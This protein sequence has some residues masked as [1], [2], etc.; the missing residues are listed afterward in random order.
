MSV[1]GAPRDRVDGK[2]K[3]TG[4]AKYSAEF[5]IA[6][7]AYAV[8]IESTIPSGSVASID[9]AQASRGKGVLAILTPANAPK[10]ANPQS[11]LSLLQDN[12]VYY[13]KQPIG[14]VVADSLNAAWH[15]A[16][17]VHVR[18]Q[19]TAARL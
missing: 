14:I 4:A 3:V 12:R 11:R 10:L 16:S 9:M 5:Q 2:A 8:L 13:N 18:Y 15:A 17:L 1:L 19:R 6:N 7:L